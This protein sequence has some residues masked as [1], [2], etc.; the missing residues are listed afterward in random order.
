MAVSIRS[1]RD[2]SRA[3]TAPLKVAVVV[4]TEVK[5]IGWAVP[6]ALLQ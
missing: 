3:A 5:V 2:S 4:V 6:D 1:A